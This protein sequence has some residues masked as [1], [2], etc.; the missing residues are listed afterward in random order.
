MNIENLVEEITREVMETIGNGRLKPIPNVNN[1]N[2]DLKTHKRATLL[3]GSKA[4]VSKVKEAVSFLKRQNIDVTIAIHPDTYTTN[5]YDSTIKCS[6]YSECAASIRNSDEIYIL[7]ADVSTVS[8]LSNLI[9]DRFDIESVLYAIEMGKKVVAIKAFNTPSPIRKKVEDMLKEIK[10][11][12]IEIITLPD[13][14]TPSREEPIRA[15]SVSPVPTSCPQSAGGECAGC[16][17]CANL[18]Q[19]RI[20]DLVKEGAERLSATSGISSVPSDIAKLIDHTLLKPDATRDQI[21]KLCEEAKRYGFASCC[22][23]PTWVST[24]AECLKGSPVK[25]CVVIG[26]PLGANSTVIKAME[27]RDAIASGADEVDMVINVGALKAGD[28]DLVR[29]DIEAVVE[30]AQGRIVKVI[31]ETALLTDEEKVKACQIAKQAGADYVKTSTGFGPGG[32]T[33][34][35]VA[36]MRRTVGKY[37][38]VKASGGIR[39]FKKATEMIKAGA[40]RIG[41][42]ASVSIIKGIKSNDKGY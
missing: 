32:A 24:V 41:A 3:V 6:S 22:V 28:Y 20:R 38:G 42:S 21:I 39:D 2:T 26:F 9:A 37:M 29:R 15:S 1:T 19:D 10:D 8:R 30:A 17:L 25:T 27:T 5:I 16:G 33:V 7:L 36:L 14:Y 35:D 12:S 4:D 13:S 34:E 11:F 31:I 40:T 18:N 23:N